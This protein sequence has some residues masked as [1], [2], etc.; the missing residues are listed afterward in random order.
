MV[1]TLTRVCEHC[2]QPLSGEPFCFEGGVYCCAGCAGGGPCACIDAPSAQPVIVRAGGFA[3]QV[4]LLDFALDL[5]RHP[6][7]AE[8]ALM[9]GDLEDAWFAVT[10]ARGGTV[11]AALVTLPGFEVTVEPSTVSLAV[12]VRRAGAPGEQP[13]PTPASVEVAAPSG[14][15]RADEPVSAPESESESQS[16]SGSG[17]GFEPAPATALAATARPTRNR[18]RGVLGGVCAGIADR[19]D[20]DLSLIRAVTVLLT[21]ATGGLAA[22]VY[23]AL[24]WRLH[25]SAHADASESQGR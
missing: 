13:A 17:S 20:Y 14:A 6:A 21:V 23:L 24:W 5:E 7:V 3:T 8:V 19:R 16:Q 2:E 12:T 15:E 25:A 4:E 9:R 1:E 11:H 18:D 22:I 10:A